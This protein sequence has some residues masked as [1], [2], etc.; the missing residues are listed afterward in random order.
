MSR[1][2]TSPRRLL[3]AVLAAVCCGWLGVA[4]AIARQG[5]QTDL[6]LTTDV[7]G[8]ITPVIANHLEDV[9]AL[10]AERDAQALIVI[11]DTPGGLVT[12]MREIVQTFFEAEVP[13]VVYVSPRGADAGSAGTYITM[14]AHVAVMAPAT[15]IGAAT[16][17]DLQGGDI[18][19]KIKNNAAAFAETIADER[20]RNVEFAIDAVREGRSITVTDAV[21]LGVVDFRAD[22]LED[23]LAQLDGRDVALADGSVVTI[24]SADA[25]V[26]TV[27]LSGT[28]SILQRLADPNLA[29]IFLSI[30]TLAIIYEIASPGLGAGGV[31]GVTLIILAMFSLSVLPVNYAGAALLVLAGVLFVLELFM[32]GVGVAAAGGAVTL[33]LGGLFLFQQPTGIGVD[34]SIVLPTAVVVLALTLVAGRLARRTLHQIPVDNASGLIGRTATASVRD[35]G[36]V[37]VRV[38]GTWWRAE[39]ASHLDD[40]QQVTI[41]GIDELTLTVAPA[42]ADAQTTSA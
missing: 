8:V 5:S 1:N 26:E 9:T 4:P 35:D 17:V 16:P 30:A 6:I 34:L 40:G 42:T 24:R 13:V 36:A 19:D 38:D 33:V 27:N 3:A 7:R 11:L 25:A 31:V 21:E 20:G 39:C 28:R 23:L 10:A 12:S 41:T 22:D 32:P 2:P 14:A 29:F 37:R 15:T 18:S